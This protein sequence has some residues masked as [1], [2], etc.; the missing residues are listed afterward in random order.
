VNPPVETVETAA[1][2]EGG[3]ATHP[4]GPAEASPRIT[5]SLLVTLAL[6][7]AI[8]PIATDLYLPAFPQMVT[9]LATST[10]GVQFSLTAFLVGAGVGQVLFGPLSDR[11]GRRAPL[12]IGAAVFV[13]ASVGAAMAPSVAVLVAFRVLQGVS[14]AAGMVIGRAVVVDLARGREAARAFTLLMM[15]GGVA[16]VIAPLV[17]SSLT[18][19]IGWR[20]L[21]WI[22]TA[23]GAVALVSVF[24]V[25]KETLPV[26]ARRESGV[27]GSLIEFRALGSRSYVGAT[28]AFAFGFTTLMSYISASPFLYQDLMGLT[29]LQYG[30]AFGANAL[31]LMGVSGVAA[32]LTMRWGS[33]R[34]ARAGLAINLG[35]ILVVGV[36]VLTDAPVRWL[37]LPILV[38]VSALGLVLGSTTALALDAVPDV[39]GGASAVLGLAQFGLAAIAAPLV[40]LG[41]GTSALPLAVTMLV[42]SVAANAGLRIASR[43]VTPAE[44]LR[45]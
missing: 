13:V 14:G 10:T 25:V 23:L 21:L 45:A 4:G 8:A 11:W 7:S 20:G 9:D 6:L 37:A 27:V 17:G 16:P 43:A 12:L 18:D 29:T 1:R 15:I 3:S 36:L 42:A 28:L 5:L 2:T 35:S 19:V 34:T 38:A 44:V 40:S 33:L 32:K 39:A 31:V 30:L 26:A 22:A 24:M 41:G